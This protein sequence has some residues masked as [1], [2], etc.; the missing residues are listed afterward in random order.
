MRYVTPDKPINSP[1]NGYTIP[2]DRLTNTMR[3][4]ESVADA[5]QVFGAEEKLVDWIS[6]QYNVEQKVAGRRVLQ[7]AD[8]GKTGA[9]LEAL[10]AEAV[11]ET[12]TWAPGEREKG[13]GSQK[14]RAKQLDKVIAIATSGRDED[15]Q[16]LAAAIA[17][18]DLDAL[19]ALMAQ[20][21]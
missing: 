17:A 13:K 12:K 3:R 1:K 16:K 11:E 5:V 18:G 6:D 21:Q 8:K 4:F 9:D 20:A 10:L 19:K 2:V 7:D 14:D 15:R